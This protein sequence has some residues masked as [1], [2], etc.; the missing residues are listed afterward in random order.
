MYLLKKQAMG[1]ENFGVEIDFLPVGEGSRSADAIAIRYGDLESGDM[2]KQ[3]VIVIDGGTKQS[4]QALVELVNKYYG[5]S[6]VDLVIM[7]HPDKDHASGL[8]E[9]MNNLTV[10]ELWM[11]QPWSHSTDIRQH[12][13]DGRITNSS[14]ER[15]LRVSM[16]IAHEVEQ[17]AIEKKIRIVEPFAGIRS[18]DAVIT[19]L[20]PSREYYQRLL[21]NFSKSKCRDSKS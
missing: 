19:V 20:G 17:I 5:T 1:T 16:D 12:F 15:R 6:Y 8:T 11:H 2:L 9:V 3:Q 4:G 10:G 21:P 7:T 18:G 14:L 13:T